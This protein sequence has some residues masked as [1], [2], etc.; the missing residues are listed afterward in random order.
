MKILLVTQFF[1]PEPTFKGL[2]LARE[3]HRRG[4]AVEVLTGFPNYPEGRIHEGWHQRPV[5]RREV[6]GVTVTRVPLWPSHDRSGLRRALTY[7]SF[8]ASASI[9]ALLVRRPDVVHV[10]H[11]P[12]TTGLAALVLKHLRGVPFVLDVQDLWPDS[13]TSTGMLRGRAPV[14]LASALVR[15]VTAA[16]EHVVT[17][18]PGMTRL[19]AERSRRPEAV[20]TLLNW[21]YEDDIEQAGASE[22]RAERTSPFVATFAGNLGPAQGLDTLLDAA[23][24]LSDRPDVRIR[25]VGDGIDAAR[26]RRRAEEERLTAVEFVGRV[27]VGEVG[28]HLAAS[29]ALIVHLRDEPLFRVT[30]PSK[31][32]AYL[33][34]GRPI[35]MA[36]RGDAA[37]LVER[38]GAGVVVPPEDAG[39][40]AEAL[41]RLADLPPSA[42]EAMGRAGRR[43]YDSELSLRRG[44][45]RLERVLENASR[46]RPRVDAAKRIGDVVGAVT[47]L[48]LA[49]PLLGVLAVVVAVGLGRPVLFRQERPG[50]DG[51]PFTLVKFRTMTDRRGPDGELLPDSDRLT[52][53]GALLRVTSLDELPG[54]LGVVRGDLSLVGPRPLH[55]RYTPWFTP[56]ERQ[57]FRCRPGLSGLAQVHGRNTASWD[58][59]LA[60]DVHYA[61][62]P[63]LWSDAGIVGRTIVA[64]LRRTGAVAEP[65]ELM[66]DLDVERR[67][68][69]AGTAAGAG[70]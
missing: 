58:D 21:T 66:A 33:L 28:Q 51:R 69:A 64:V 43:W 10:Y 11:P 27:P 30:V 16:A 52:R 67:A 65:T 24:L 59:R 19:V 70:S 14:A 17:L 49:A 46:A 42:R 8:A 3:L 62:N 44:V 39:A 55:P 22:A 15:R 45:E 57:R 1:D 37:E 25:V 12:A 7:G 60:L 50:R 26:L 4:H 6:D 20:S 18:S 32:Q 41:L 53:L 61:R 34:A 36:V 56:D 54:L 13:L 38:A 68:S 23:A 31:T 5:D 63:S 9:A 47:L 2:L 48:V 35:V 40:L 29:D